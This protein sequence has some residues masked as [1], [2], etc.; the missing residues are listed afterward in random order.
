MELVTK[1]TEHMIRLCLCLLGIAGL[2]AA[3][4]AERPKITG[5]AHA[6]FFVR[7]SIRRGSFTKIC[8]DTRNRSR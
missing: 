5:V 2:V 8:W 1:H 6:A 3:Q 4:E 7:I